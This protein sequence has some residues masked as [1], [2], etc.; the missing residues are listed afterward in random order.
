MKQKELD[1]QEQFHKGILDL[2]KQRQEEIDHLKGELDMCSDKLFRAEGH[3]NLLKEELRKYDDKCQLLGETTS[4]EVSDL[5]SGQRPTED[6][7][8]DELILA[9]KYAERFIQDKE[10][11]EQQHKWEVSQLKGFYE[12]KLAGDSAEHQKVLRQ[13]LLK[14]QEAAKFIDSNDN[15]EAAKQKIGDIISSAFIEL[16]NR[17]EAEKRIGEE[18]VSAKDAC[19]RMNEL[20]T[21]ILELSNELSKVNEEAN[22]DKIKAS[23]NQ[24]YESEIQRLK[25]RIHYKKKLRCL[26]KK[27]SS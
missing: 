16:N 12:R 26:T 2:S 17:L 14:M 10:A 19:T 23:K 21:R 8:V 13:I 24:V 27:S 20:T 7:K 22:A 1:L 9:R 25:E 15:D 11:I 3:I 6:A 4:H 5:I 18:T